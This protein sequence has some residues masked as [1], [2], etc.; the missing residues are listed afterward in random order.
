MDAMQI[1]DEQTEIIAKQNRLI[2]SITSQLLQHTAIDEEERRSIRTQY[3]E[4]K[5]VEKGGD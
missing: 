1:I 3:G 5:E 2:N 4:R